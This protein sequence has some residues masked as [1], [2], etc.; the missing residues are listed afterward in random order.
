MHLSQK[1]ILL[2]AAKEIEGFKDLKAAHLLFGNL[3]AHLFNDGIIDEE[4]GERLAASVDFGR[5]MALKYDSEL[6]LS[7]IHLRMCIRDR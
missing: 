6:M 3:D 5:A 4:G 7:L 1:E 2:H